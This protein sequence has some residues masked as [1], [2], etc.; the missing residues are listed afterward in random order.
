[1]MKLGGGGVGGGGG[2]NVI[3]HVVKATTTA[4]PPPP[5]PLSS[6]LL[7]SFHVFVSALPTPT[8][9]AS[10]LP[11]PLFRWSR[12]CD[13][14]YPVFAA[15]AEGPYACAEKRLRVWCILWEEVNGV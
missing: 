14:R 7:P 1:M 11:K 3:L 13:F 10:L 5:P 8:L 6:P 2:N 15:Y 12:G 4:P 9:K